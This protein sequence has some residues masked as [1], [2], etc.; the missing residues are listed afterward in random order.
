MDPLSLTASIIAVTQLAS[1]IISYLNEAKDASKEQLRIATEISNVSALLTPLKSRIASAKPTEPWF[2]TIQ[3]LGDKD[4]PLEQFVF[5]LESIKAK[6]AKVD[7]GLNRAVR[8]LTWSFNKSEVAEMVA[9][10]ERVKMLV[11]LAL[12]NDTL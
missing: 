8:V 7:G 3:K 9:R 2:A 6:V 5:T 12:A 11:I 1:N 10:I 4:G